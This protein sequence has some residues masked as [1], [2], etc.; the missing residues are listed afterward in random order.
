MPRTL[1]LLLSLALLA[2][3][4]AATRGISSMPD[5]ARPILVPEDGIRPVPPRLE[6]PGGDAAATPA[7][8]AG[9]AAVFSV[10]L[11]PGAIQ[12]DSTYYDL[13]D[14]GSMGEHIVTSP[15]GRVLAT[16]EDDLCNLDAGGCPP[17]LSAVQPYPERGMAFTTRTAGGTWTGTSK[18]QD[19]TV[20]GCCITE[21]FGGFGT[22]ALAPDGRAVISQAVSEDGCD[23]RGNMY[24]QNAQ[25]GTTFMEY[26]TPIVSPSNLFPQVVALPNGSF[27]VMGEVPRVV[28]GCTHCGVDAIDVSRLPAAGAAFVCPTGWQCGPWTS[29]VNMSMFKG[30]YSGFPSMASGSD[31]RVGIA[32]PEIGGNLWL[33]QS[34]DG[35]FSPATVT[36]RNLTGYS[37]AS[38]TAPDSTSTQYRPSINCYVAYNDTTPNVV[39]AELQARKIGTAIYYVDWRSK[40]RHWNSIEGA[41]TVKQV[42]NGEAD[43]YD[44]VYNG[45]SGPIAGFNHISV[46]WPQVGFSPDGSETY[47]VWS[48]FVD[49]EVDPTANA[50]QPGFVTG[51]G[52][53]D[54]VASVHRMGGGWSTPQDLTNT[55][56][57]DDRYPSIPARG[58]VAGK[59]QLFYQSSATNQAGVIQG[60][61]RGTTPVNLVRRIVYLETPLAGSVLAAPRTTLAGGLRIT[62]NPARGAVRFSLPAGGS[63]TTVD[64]YAVNGALV[65]RVPVGAGGEAR[66]DGRD[67]DAR[68]LPSGVYLARVEG[69]GPATKLL[70]MR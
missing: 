67:R 54:I 45:Y 43:S 2:P 37:D 22:I 25:G 63:G 31:G 40:V 58:N 21:H 49:A 53:G 51:V 29:V 16:W 46:D 38:I 44:N 33:L 60:Q 34:S 9:V 65:A 8:A 62:P 59:I 48:R 69:A 20:W 5:R 27:D 15:D 32:I 64:V 35:T 6:A 47:V 50:G 24:L 52:F 57:A 39:W 14:L 30:G 61:D 36:L 23:L 56:N 26:L 42:Q 3:A 11:P 68:P 28:T 1:A 55:P 66:W 7:G 18:L 10:P 19:P 12:V 17:N 41:S 13:Q 4:S 70:F